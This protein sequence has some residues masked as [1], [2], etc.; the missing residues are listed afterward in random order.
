MFVTPT[1]EL[2]Y[3]NSEA[4]ALI[5]QMEGIGL[6]PFQ[7]LIGTPQ[8]RCPPVA[9]GLKAK[10]KLE[11][12]PA[13]NIGKSSSVSTRTAGLQQLKDFLERQDTSSSH[14]LLLPTPTCI[15]RRLQLKEPDS[16]SELK[17]CVEMLPKTGTK[18]LP[19]LKQEDSTTFLPTFISG[20]IV[21]SEKYQLITSLL[22]LLK[23]KSMFTG[24]EQVLERVNLPGKEQGWMLTLRVPQPNGGTVIEAM[25]TLLLTSSEETLTLDTSFGGSTGIRF[26]LKTKEV[27]A[28]LKLHKYGL[29]QIYH[30]TLGFP[31]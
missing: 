11:K 16:S 29:R 17:P 9:V 1:R 6:E 2:M 24:V 22:N 31:L 28:F 20:A 15:K 4:Y 30:P 8:S 3:I 5:C 14:D 21:L 13:T 25:L 19:M 12:Q 10:L 26:L 23:D 7:D 27:P 18:S